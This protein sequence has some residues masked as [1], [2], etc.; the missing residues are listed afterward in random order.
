MSYNAFS[1][2]TFIHEYTELLKHDY[3]GFTARP[4]NRFR[5]EETKWWIVPTT[6]WPSFGNEKLCFWTSGKYL[7]G[8][9][10]VEKGIQLTSDGNLSNEN[11]EPDLLQ[12]KKNL[13]MTEDWK[14]NR[15]IDDC[16]D[17]VIDTMVDAFNANVNFPVH[18]VVSA[19]LVNT[20]KSYDPYNNKQTDNI[21]F[22][23]TKES[24][25]VCEK[26]YKLSVLSPFENIEG[27]KEI[28][29]TM[30]F[31]KGINWLWIDV[32]FFAPI[33]YIKTGSSYNLEKLRKKMSVF[34]ERI[35]QSCKIS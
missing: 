10:N 24:L 16:R 22:A 7:Y 5:P 27:I 14:W 34:E 29:E 8:G 18:M 13:I 6:A 3:E 20:I 30:D 9:F 19:N 1:I 4:W 31:V 35:F 25:K 28:S 32:M 12:K 26:D 23:I 2:K 21:E 11:C 33:H 15:F 17:G